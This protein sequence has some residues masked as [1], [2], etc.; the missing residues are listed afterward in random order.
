MTDVGHNQPPGQIEFSKETGDALSQ[1]MAN[2]PVIDSEEVAREAKLLLDRG[3]ACSKDLAQER[4]E[5]TGPLLKTVEEIR[6]EYREPQSTLDSIV[7]ELQARIN[8]FL[9]KL[10][11][12]RRAAAEKL[13]LEA[14]EAERLA[15]SMEALEQAAKED[16]KQGILDV[17]IAATTREA[18]Q[19]YS[20]FKEVS[21]AAARAGR[22]AQH[23]AIGGGFRRAASLRKKETLVVADYEAAIKHM[24]LT[25][26]IRDAILTE[27][28]AFRKAFDELPD[29]IISETTRG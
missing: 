22:E 26:A 8:A 25:D 15:R 5:R 10:E 16:A 18:D 28:R 14:E 23:V 13:R 9:I 27:A 12:Q 7:T 19:A 11:E 4:Q 3:S 29:G 1:W 6:A 24:G 21:L 17:D 2:H 20:R